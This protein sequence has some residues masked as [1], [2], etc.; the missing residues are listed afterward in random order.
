MSVTGCRVPPVGGC[1]HFDFQTSGVNVTLCLF[2]HGVWGSSAC[3]TTCVA[4]N[5]CAVSV[6]CFPAPPPHFL[7]WCVCL[8]LRHVCHGLFTVLRLSGSL[9][10]ACFCRDMLLDLPDAKTSLLTI[11]AVEFYREFSLPAKW[12]HTRNVIHCMHNLCFEAS[13]R[14][15]VTDYVWLLGLAGQCISLGNAPSSVPIH[16]SVS[17]DSGVLCVVSGI[18]DMMITPQ[19]SVGW[20]IDR[21][22]S[23]ITQRKQPGSVKCL[24]RPPLPYRRKPRRADWTDCLHCLN[25]TPSMPNITLIRYVP[26]G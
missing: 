3:V 5:G 4:R 23:S 2:C 17:F 11:S 22:I 9:L 14:S 20:S 25:K 15:L 12:N 10:V 21:A 13:R 19:S 26:H 18:E 6:P 8:R 1:G 16:T 7:A 24:P